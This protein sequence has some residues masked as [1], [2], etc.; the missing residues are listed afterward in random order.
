MRL[1][2]TKA[3]GESDSGGCGIV[4]LRDSEDVGE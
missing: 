1:L 2:E 3:V 4:R